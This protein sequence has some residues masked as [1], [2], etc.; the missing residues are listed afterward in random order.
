MHANKENIMINKP[1]I[2][3]LVEITGSNYLLCSLVSK[4]ARQIA[5]QEIYGNGIQNFPYEKP[6]T[7]AAMEVIDDLL[8]PVI[9]D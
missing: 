5:D 6:V 4:R 8:K 9:E 3:Q 2:D 7:A 1:S